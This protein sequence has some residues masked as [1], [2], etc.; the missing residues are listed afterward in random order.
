MSKTFA[1]FLSLRFYEGA[2]DPTPQE[3]S[4]FENAAYYERTL[5]PGLKVNT[6]ITGFL[7]GP[8]EV[9]STNLWY[10]LAAAIIECVST[11]FIL[12]TYLGFWKLGRH[13]TFS[14]LEIAKVR[15]IASY[16]VPTTTD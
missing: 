12:P 15:L 2:M 1:N 5:D 8:H 13:V 6:T 11:A 14:P 10:F 7:N 16:R 3:D 4:D 9:Y